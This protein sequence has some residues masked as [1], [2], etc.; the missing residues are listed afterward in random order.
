[1]G[2][3]AFETAETDRTINVSVVGDESA[4][5]KLKQES[6]YAESDGDLILNFNG[7]AGV[8][9]S[10]INTN[11]DYS[12]TGVFSI[13][14]H[15]SQPVGVW[16]EDNDNHDVKYG[17]PDITKWYAA[18]SEDNSDFSTSMQGRGNAYTIGVGDTVF[19]NV[20][21]LLNNN[22]YYENLP[23]SLTISADA[24]EAEAEE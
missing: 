12:F 17:N 2:T 18:E 24:S 13:T 4:F 3:G 16:V 5:L 11:S 7:D 19:V 15:G 22:H 20:E 14:N 21:I 8:T 23:N 1:M 6:P 9:G 10:G